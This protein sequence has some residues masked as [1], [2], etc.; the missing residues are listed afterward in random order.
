MVSGPSVR[1]GRESRASD[2]APGPASIRWWNIVGTTAG[3]LDIGAFHAPLRISVSPS[4]S[5]SFTITVSPASRVASFAGSRVGALCR[6][7]VRCC[8]PRASPSSTAWWAWI[9][10][11]FST[12]VSAVS[13]GDSVSRS[14]STEAALSRLGGVT[15]ACLT[16]GTAPVAGAAYVPGAA[17]NV[18]GV[19]WVPD[20]T[21]VPP[22]SGIELCGPVASRGNRAR[23]QVASCIGVASSGEALMND[24]RAC[25]NS[26]AVAR[27]SRLVSSAHVI[28]F[29]SGGGVC[30]ATVEIGATLPSRIARIA[31]IA[32]PRATI[33]L[34][35]SSSHITIA[36]EN[37]S[38]RP[39]SGAAIVCSG[40]MY[41]YL[42]LTWPGWVSWFVSDA[43]FAIPKSHSLTTPSYD[44]MRFAGDTSR[45]TS[46]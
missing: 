21:P 19:A 25:A 12:T 24:S 35:L 34:P 15:G 7:V 40:D 2:P 37:T 32:S 17:A 45:C 11:W 13:S 23:T 42:P 36:S 4:A 9:S 43:A 33:V 5:V 18:P 16:L 10:S 30:G 31:S 29:A 46:P 22:S 6:S 20:T 28:A 39:S 38:L 44:T 1:P 26:A 41:A 8:G 3:P 14:I 27:R